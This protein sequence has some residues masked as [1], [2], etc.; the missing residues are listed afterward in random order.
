M[1][2]TAFLTRPLAF[3]LVLVCAFLLRILGFRALH[4]CVKACPIVGNCEPRLV[5]TRTASITKAI[6][7]ASPFAALRTYCLTRSAA[8]TCLLRLNGI[9][10]KVA[11]G[12][13]RFPF[14]AHAW[15][16]VE[17][18]ALHDPFL[19]TEGYVVLDRI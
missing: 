11:I 3:A 13:R 7:R 4:Q 1:T 14:S 17:C 10:A 6:E 12:V 19:I 2:P 9:K 5:A 18:K 8:T 16:E 15:V